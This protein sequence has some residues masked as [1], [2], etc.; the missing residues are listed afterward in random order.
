MGQPDGETFPCFV[1]PAQPGGQV[2]HL[3]PLVASSCDGPAAVWSSGDSPN[4]F[5]ALGAGPDATI[6]LDCDT[7]TAGTH[8][9]IISDADCGCSAALT[10][11]AAAGQLRVD[12][13]AGMCLTDGAVAGALPSCAGN[14]TVVPMQLHLARCDGP[15]TTGWSRIEEAP[16]ATAMPVNATLA[17]VGAYLSA[18]AAA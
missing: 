10:F 6:N 8:A 13:C 1:G 7:C 16:V 5:Y 17:F 2:F 3:C 4:S 9:K 11:D 14:E 18:A 12:A 15:G